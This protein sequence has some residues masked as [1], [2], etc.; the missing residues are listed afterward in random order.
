MKKTII[1]T[2]FF[3]Y[4][5]LMGYA[6]KRVEFPHEVVLRDTLN[7]KYSSKLFY[8]FGKP[9]IIEFFASYCS[10]C[11]SQLN[12]FKE[13]YKD[14][15]QQ[16]GVK[17][18]VISVDSRNLHKKTLKMIRKHQWPFPFYFDNDRKLTHK[19]S[20]LGGTP[21]TVIYDGDFNIRAKFI[22]IKSNSAYKINK[23][24]SIAKVRVHNNNKYRHLACDLT[25]YEEVLKK[26]TKT[27]VD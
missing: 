24:G 16:Y 21:E 22:G 26:I 18:I 1:F 3:F 5:L 10:P 15:Q 20:A 14:W 13:V 4:F 27:H 11:I 6:Q 9:I 25:R 2:L 17:I 7:K 12:S 8:N 23:D 19:I